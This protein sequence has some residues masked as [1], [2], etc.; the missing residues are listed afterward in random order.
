MTVVDLEARRVLRH[1]DVLSKAGWTPYAGRPTPG[2]EVA[3][4]VE[5]G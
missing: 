5:S 3:G 2:R 4:R 1:E